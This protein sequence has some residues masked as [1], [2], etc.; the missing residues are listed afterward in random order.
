MKEALGI[1]A[2]HCGGYH[3]ITVVLFVEEAQKNLD[4][5]FD[6]FGVDL[7]RLREKLCPDGCQ[8]AIPSGGLPEHIFRELYDAPDARKMRVCRL[9][10]FELLLR[11]DT[12]DLDA[13]VEHR[14]Y[15]YRTRVEKVKAIERFITSNPE[16]RYTLSELS[17]RFEIPLTSMKLCFKGVFGSSVYSY[18][19]GWRMS[20]AAV[21]LRQTDDSVALIASSMGYDNASKF[22]S[23]FRGVMGKSPSEYRRYP[24]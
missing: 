12:L 9:K 22:S 21:L 23:A 6:G 8:R 11:L 19:C 16:K 20:A 4:A 10:I 24:V 15:F 14:P 5:A 2:H 18:M 3:G 13:N 7:V 17:R 1:S